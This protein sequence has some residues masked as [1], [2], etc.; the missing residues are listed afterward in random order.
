MGAGHGNAV[1]LED[2]GLFAG[3]GLQCG[4]QVLHVVQRDVGDNDHAQVE[5]VGRV[6][7]AAQA[8]LAHQQVDAR[9]GEVVKRR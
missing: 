5:D 6:Q 8:H 7:P 4:P 1:R 9:P 3:D 2:A